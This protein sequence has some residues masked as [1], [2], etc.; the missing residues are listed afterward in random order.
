MSVGIDV[1]AH[2]IAAIVLAAIITVLMHQVEL[3][4]EK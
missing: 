2:S 3:M 1:I 4:F